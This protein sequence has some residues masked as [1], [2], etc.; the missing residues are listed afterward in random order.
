MTT[1]K[2]PRV[3]YP[4]TDLPAVVKDRDGEKWFLNEDGMYSYEHDCK[5]GK[6]LAGFSALVARYGPLIEVFPEFPT[7]IGSVIRVNDYLMVR[8]RDGWVRAELPQSV[9]LIVFPDENI[10]DVWEEVTDL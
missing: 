6:S 4:H 1:N 5:N 2:S 8:V 3:F 10:G 7:K 9:D